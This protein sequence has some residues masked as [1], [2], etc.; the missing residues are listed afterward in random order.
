MD[1]GLLGVTL[2]GAE[3]SPG[4][5]RRALTTWTTPEFLVDSD[6]EI[7]LGVDGEALTMPTPVT[8]RIRPAALRVRIAPRHPGASPAAAQPT[9]L[10]DGLRRIVLIAFG[11][12]P[13][14]LTAGPAARRSEP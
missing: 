6:G 1:E 3:T 14:E 7:P 8:F 5:R 11:T 13:A 10:I 2:M 4:G 12:D 9:G